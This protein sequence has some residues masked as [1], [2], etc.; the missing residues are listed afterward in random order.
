LEGQN[1]VHEM[2]KGASHLINHRSN[3]PYLMKRRACFF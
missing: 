1:S 2:K 3:Q